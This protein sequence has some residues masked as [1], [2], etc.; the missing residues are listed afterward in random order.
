M[1]QF[2]LPSCVEQVISVIAT[3][4]SDRCEDVINDSALRHTMPETYPSGKISCSCGVTVPSYHFAA[5][6]APTVGTPDAIAGLALR[7]KVL[8]M[9]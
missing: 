1:G 4:R 2:S 8:F 6:G 3:L 9:G 5:N 7:V